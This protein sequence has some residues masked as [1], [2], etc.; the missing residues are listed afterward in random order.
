M[1]RFPLKDEQVF[2]KRVV[3]TGG[4]TVAV[5]D[6]RLIVNGVPRD[7]QFLLERPRCGSGRADVLMQNRYTELAEQRQ[8]QGQ[9]RPE[10]NT[11]N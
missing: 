2:I 6:G 5:R 11:P 9:R 10:S 3:A 4:D 8:G 1:C 7:E